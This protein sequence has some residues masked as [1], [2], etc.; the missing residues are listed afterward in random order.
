VPSHTT[1]E[2]FGVDS[3]QSWYSPA[4]SPTTVRRADFCRVNEARFANQLLCRKCQAYAPA[5]IKASAPK[6]KALPRQALPLPRKPPGTSHCAACGKKVNS[7]VVAF[8]LTNRAR[9]NGRVLCTNCQ[10]GVR[11]NHRTVKG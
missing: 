9:Y 1:T 10:L 3:F 6:P 5:Q 4:R 11:Q 7:S 8:C 2:L